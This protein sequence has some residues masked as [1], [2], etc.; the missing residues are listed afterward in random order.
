M[1]IND[2]DDDDDDDDS[3]IRR[4]ETLVRLRIFMPTFLPDTVRSKNAARSP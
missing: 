1:E 2:D 3:Q 4:L